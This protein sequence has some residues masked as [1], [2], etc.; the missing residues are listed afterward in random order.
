MVLAARSR[1]R[2]FLRPPSPAHL[3]QQHPWQSRCA[4][5]ERHLV[6]SGSTAEPPRPPQKWHP[7]QPQA[8]L[9]CWPSRYHPALPST[10]TLPSNPLQHRVFA[11]VS[12]AKLIRGTAT[13]AFIERS[14]GTCL[15]FPA[16]HSSTTSG[17]CFCWGQPVSA[18]LAAPSR[19]QSSPRQANPPTTFSHTTIPGSLLHALEKL[20]KASKSDYKVVRAAF[21]SACFCGTRLHPLGSVAIK[22]TGLVTCRVGTTACSEP[23]HASPLP[24]PPPSWLLPRS[25]EASQAKQ[26]KTM[27]EQT[28]EEKPTIPLI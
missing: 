16:R 1:S 25:S 8:P 24:V 18:L 7:G 27:K 3:S 11:F 10:S 20:R 22:T 13:A 4:K 26:H 14:V 23:Q 6:V 21:V 19:A 2:Y 28:R 5:A 17:S 12:R 15:N 9:S